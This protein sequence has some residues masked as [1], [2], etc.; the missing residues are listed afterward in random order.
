ML[1]KSVDPAVDSRR[2]LPFENTAQED[3]LQEDTLHEHALHEQTLHE[4]TLHEH[5]PREP[6]V[7]DTALMKERITSRVTITRC[8]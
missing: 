1:T 7:Y 3:T 2:Q 8:P 5:T 4:H 6:T